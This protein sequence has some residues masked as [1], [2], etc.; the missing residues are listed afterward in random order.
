MAIRVEDVGN[1][2]ANYESGFESA[3]INQTRHRIYLN[4]E[5]KVRVILPFKTNEVEISDLH[6]LIHN[7]L[8]KDLQFDNFT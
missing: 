1:I 3:G 6:N 5:S 2:N 7:Q 8:Q 4:V